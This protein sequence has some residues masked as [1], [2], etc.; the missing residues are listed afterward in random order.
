MFVSFPQQLSST[1]A[2][3]LLHIEK[4][5]LVLLEQKRTLTVSAL[6]VFVALVRRGAEEKPTGL[7][8]LAEELGI[9]IGS[10][11][12][13]LDALEYFDDRGGGWIERIL[14]REDRRQRRIVFTRS[15]LEMARTIMGLQTA[16]DG[17]IG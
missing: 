5:L 10:L 17:G 14:D 7:R 13:Q 1:Q 15:G 9:P 4:L 6:L 16:E 3:Q 11:S 2:L 12:R 8:L